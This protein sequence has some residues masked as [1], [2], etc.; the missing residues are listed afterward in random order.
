MSKLSRELIYHDIGK[1][2]V[3]RYK[4]CEVDCD[5]VVQ[6]KALKALRA[7]QHIV[8]SGLDDFLKVDAIVDVF[9]K[10]GIDFGPCHDF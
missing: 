6:T 1:T 9:I 10:Y 7:V 4:V 3:E 8:H 2:M 5:A